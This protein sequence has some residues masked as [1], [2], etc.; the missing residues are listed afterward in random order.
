MFDRQWLLHQESQS[1]VSVQTLL[2]QRGVSEDQAAAFLNPRLADLEDPFR[3]IGMEAAVERILTAADT[4]E[5]ITVLG[6]YDADGITATAVLVHFL[7]TYLQANVHYYIPDRFAE[8]YGM[9]VEAVEQLAAQGATLLITVDNGISAAIPAQRAVDLGVDLIITDHHQCP[10]V[11]PHCLA[12]LNPHLPESGFLFA[13]LAGVGVAYTLVRALGACIGLDEQLYDYL[14]IVALGTIGDCVPLVGQNRILVHGG[15]TRML[16]SSWMGLTALLEKTGIDVSNGQRLTANIL[17]FRVIPKLN[18]VG[19]LGSAARAVELLLSEDSDG[20]MA[21]AQCLLDENQKRQET[22]LAIYR[23]IMQGHGLLSQE[24]DA[25]VVAYGHDWHH[26][27]IGLVASRLVEQYGKPAIVFAGDGTDERGISRLKGS[28]RSVKGFHL[29]QAFSQCST[30]LEKF[31]GHEMAAGLTVLETNLPAMIASLNHYQ[32]TVYAQT[33]QPPHRIADAVLSPE[34]VTI[35]FIQSLRGL[36][37]FGEENPEPVFI[38]NDLKLSKVGA[39]GNE[40][41]HLRFSFCGQNSQ[42]QSVYLDGI[43]FYTGALLPLMQTVGRCAVLCTL[44]IN[45]WQGVSKPS[46][47]ILD[48]HD[49]HISLEKKSQCLYNNAYTTFEG[50]VLTRECLIAV[51]KAIVSMGAHWTVQDLAKLRTALQQAGIPCSWYLLQSAISVFTEIGLVARESD[52]VYA[53]RKIE[54]KLQLSQS[55][56]YRT[57]ASENR[58]SSSVKKDE[59]VSARGNDS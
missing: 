13:D 36:E 41:Q 4:G 31:G 43:S 57:I 49:S 37:P 9:S 54:G 24:S 48:L 25:V 18:A 53:L 47:R 27:V 33:W 1:G 45:T 7:R 44:D 11:L 22:E 2:G 50:F 58:S 14:P 42:G 59:R 52:Q 39:V 10:P 29:Y 23:E 16:H 38:I 35:P 19:R 28:A 32:E 30:I 21:M 34:H 17:A 5:P 12:I 56:L 6:D 40:G 8:G 26:G 51:Y 20:A 46:L 15:M 55:P 3:P